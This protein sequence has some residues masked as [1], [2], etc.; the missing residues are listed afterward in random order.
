MNNIDM[1]RTRLRYWHKR[2][3]PAQIEVK[4]GIPEMAIR[5]FCGTDVNTPP[6]MD[7]VG[8]DDAAL[9]SDQIAAIVNDPRFAIP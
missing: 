6:G 4:T 5:A 8:G 7:W 9:S 1:A 3:T 2:P